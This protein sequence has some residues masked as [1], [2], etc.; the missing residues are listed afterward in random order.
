MEAAGGEGDSAR[1]ILNPDN[2]ST[3]FIVNTT[4]GTPVDQ[5]LNTVSSPEYL[6]P[7]GYAFNVGISGGSYMAMGAAGGDLSPRFILDIAG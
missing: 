7:H 3:S 2:G 5:N 6:G 4:E 1:R